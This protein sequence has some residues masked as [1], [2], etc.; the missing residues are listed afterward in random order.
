MRTM[1][2]SHRFPTR[3]QFLATTLAA[4]AAGCSRSRET[5]D[6]RFRST[7]KVGHLVGICMSPLFV[8]HANGYFKDE[9]LDVELVFMPNPGDATSALTGGALQFIHNPFTNT[10]SAVSNGAPLKIIAGSGNGGLVCIA[11][12]ATGITNLTDLKAKA[13]T[14]L[15]VGSER[16]NTLELTFYRTIA[17]LGLTYDDFDMVWFTDHFAMAAAFQQ[18]EVDVVTHVEPYSTMLMDQF[19]GVALS[20]SFDVW[21][22]G[23]PDCVIS[24]RTDFIER[25]PLTVRQ[26]IRAVLKA[27]AFIKAQPR[28]AVDVLD[29]GKY[30]KVDRATLAAAMPRQP[31]GVDLRT[32]VKGME[33]AIDDMVRLGYLKT[34]PSNVV[35]L[36]HLADAVRTAA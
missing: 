33:T 8:A 1:M 11:Q 35:D 32:G 18:H 13:R 7:I 5:G 20:T 6:Q 3:R 9:G 25:Y 26:Y 10:Y 15:K 28:E 34:K 27:D 30:Y 23:S 17:N 22:I 14:G 19:G 16:I 21:G 2:T 31:P 12:K 29:K 4:V 36:S 24:A